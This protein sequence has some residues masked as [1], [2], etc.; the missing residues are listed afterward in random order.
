[1]KTLISVNLDLTKMHSTTICSNFFFNVIE[2]YTTRGSHVFF[3]FVDFT[4][5]FD[6]VN[7]FKLFSGLLNDGVNDCVV[8]LLAY[9]Y[10]HHD[11]AVKWVHVISDS[12]RIGYGTCQGSLLPPYLYERY[13]RGLLKMYITPELTVILVVYSIISLPMLTTLYSL[14]LHG[15]QCDS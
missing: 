5:A 14:P 10:S 11:F 15:K 12:F 8:N 6:R 7:Y 13:I 4:K 2:Y 1:M 3:C 9:W